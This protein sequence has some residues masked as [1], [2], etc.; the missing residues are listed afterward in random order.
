MVVFNC[1]FYCFL[2]F[3]SLDR[4]FAASHFVYRR[5][6][7]K[8]EHVLPVTTSPY[9]TGVRSRYLLPGAPS[10]SLQGPSPAVGPPVPTQLFK[11][12]LFSCL[13]CLLCCFVFFVGLFS[14]DAATSH[15]S[16]GGATTVPRAAASVIAILRP[17][18]R[19]PAKANRRYLS[20]GGRG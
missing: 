15:R 11:H 7:C 3:V 20:S 1:C 10:D 8:H 12:T 16:G 6:R 17:P 14:A 4:I 2:L 5:P 13:L 19:P 18:K 9:Q